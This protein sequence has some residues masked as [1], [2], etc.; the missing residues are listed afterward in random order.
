VGNFEVLWSGIK[1]YRLEDEE[2]RGN[3]LVE[4]HTAA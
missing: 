4:M 2:L 1:Q 3:Q